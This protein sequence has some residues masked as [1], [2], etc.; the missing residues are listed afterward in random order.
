M[1]V[2][3]APTFTN[4]CGTYKYKDINTMIP[5]QKMSGYMQHIYRTQSYENSNDI[6]QVE[7]EKTGTIF[8]KNTTTNA[9]AW[10]PQKLLK[11]TNNKKNN[12]FFKDVLQ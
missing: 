11:H 4:K 8:W 1:W 9:T 10:T 7:C 2:Q 6:V 3:A 12:N 5:V